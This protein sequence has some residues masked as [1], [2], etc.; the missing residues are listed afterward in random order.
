MRKILS[1]VVVVGLGACAVATTEPTSDA[2]D[3]GAVVVADA[4]PSDGAFVDAAKIPDAAP[5]VELDDAGCPTRLPAAIGA[6]CSPEGKA[7]GG[8][9]ANPCEFCNVLRCQLGKWERLEV[10]PA[11]CDAGTDGG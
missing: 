3:G 7:C 11:P 10:F 9:C 8:A 4:A 6:P 5:A 1:I 2:R